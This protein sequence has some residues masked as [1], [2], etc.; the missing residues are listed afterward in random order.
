[1]PWAAMNSLTLYS[2]TPNERGG[3]G[4]FELTGSR[5]REDYLY[6]LYAD[7]LLSGDPCLSRSRRVEATV[8]IFSLES[9]G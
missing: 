2:G 7:R 6:P 5:V 4:E 3:A 8:K 1:M 9:S